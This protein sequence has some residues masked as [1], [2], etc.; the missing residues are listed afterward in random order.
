[1]F[2]TPFV[3]SSALL[4][5]V[6]LLFLLAPRIIPSRHLPDELDDRT[7]FHRASHSSSSS[8]TF[9]H[10]GTTNPQPKIAFLFLTNSDLSFA[11]L[12]ERFFQGNQHLFNIYIHADPSSN[13][14]PPG[15]VFQGRFIPGKHTQRASPTLISA[16]RRLLATALLDDTSNSFFALLSQH[17][18]PL[19]SFR[20][21]YHSLFASTHSVSSESETH[22]T[23]STQL[24]VGQVKYRSFIEILSNEP[25]LWER[26]TARGDDVMMPEIPFERFRVGS[27]FFI[28]T[29]RHAQLVIRDRSLWRKFRLP[30]LNTESC[31]PEEHYFPTL[32][33]MKDPKGCSQFTLTRVNWTDSSDGHP[34]TYLPAEVSPELVYKLRASNSTYSYLFARKFSPDCLKPLMKLADTVIFRD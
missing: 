17:C 6:P 7:L 23:R 10:L 24:F 28:L 29:K 20:Y 27:Q 22:S 30:C 1:M 21:I 25:G 3:L 9:S 11:P 2:S 33:S 32:L 4:L 5:S 13:L 34:H 14:N 19:H 18:I 26:Y 31:Y 16:A 15:G 8:S 12:W